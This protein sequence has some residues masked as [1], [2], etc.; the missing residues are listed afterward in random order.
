MNMLHALIYGVVEGIT[1]FLP[2]SSTGHLMLTAK[3]LQSGQT[4]FLK[5]FEVAIQCGAILA[6]V[7]LYWK[8][9]IKSWAVWQRI[10]V[11]FIPTAIIGAVLYKVIKKV[12]LGSTDIVLWSL[13]IGG[14][15]LIVFEMFHRERGDALESIEAVT[16][17]QAVIIGLFQSLA[18]VPG[19]SRAAATIV[20]G[21]CVGLRR[22]TIVEFSFLLAVPT[23]AAATALDLFKSAQSFTYD[24][25]VF[26][27][28]GFIASFA[29]AVVAIRFLLAFIKRHNFIPFGV[30]RMVVAVIFWFF[31]R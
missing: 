25:A 29:V 20:G 7:V 9:F 3:I 10:M 6:V 27:S 13:F 4:D 16:V 18:V 11:A 5:T 2:I 21:L 19:V 12:F 23:M 30:Y 22:K 24:Q 31:V 8:T 15:A 17:R 14:I 26:L 28:I 1:E